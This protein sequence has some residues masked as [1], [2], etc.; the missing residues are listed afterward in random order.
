MSDNKRLLKEVRNILEKSMQKGENFKVPNVDLKKDEE[1]DFYFL[2]IYIQPFPECEGFVEEKYLEVLFKIPSKWPTKAIDIHFKTA[3]SHPNVSPE[4]DHLGYR[5]CHDV[6]SCNNS[7]NPLYAIIKSICELLGQPNPSSPLNLSSAVLYSES[8][9]KFFEQMKK[10]FTDFGK[11]EAEMYQLGE[12]RKV[13]DL[14]DSDEDK[15]T[16]KSKV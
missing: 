11:T 16:K 13:V 4:S 2:V 5:V 15:S 1:K 12:K 6:S 10:H 8:K 7:N 14:C 9:T 3:L